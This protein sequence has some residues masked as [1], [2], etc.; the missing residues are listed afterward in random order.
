MLAHRW[1]YEYI[2]GQIPE[3]L[4]IDHLCRNSSCVNPHHLEPVTRRVNLMRG[5]GPAMTRERRAAQTHCLRGHHFDETNTY[6][7]PPNGQRRCRLCHRNRERKRREVNSL[8]VI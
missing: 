3:G 5:Q 6:H 7:Q 1:A 8:A 4:E 2:I